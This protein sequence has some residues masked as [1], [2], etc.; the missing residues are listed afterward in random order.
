M[1]VD[2][3]YGPRNQSDT[4]EWRQPY[5]P[6]YTKNGIIR[7]EEE[8]EDLY[9]SI[10]AVSDKIERKLRKLKEKKNNKAGLYEVE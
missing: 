6:V 10:D 8:G 1:E 2:S 3:R 4:R 5:C 9:A 7:S